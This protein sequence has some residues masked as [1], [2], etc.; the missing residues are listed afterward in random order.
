MIILIVCLKLNQ[1]NKH[2]NKKKWWTTFENGL[3]AD[4]QRLWMNI[5]CILYDDIMNKM[6]KVWPYIDFY[7]IAAQLEVTIFVDFLE[8]VGGWLRITNID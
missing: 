1:K 4:N 2:D 5:I 6:I 7:L 8:H 3:L